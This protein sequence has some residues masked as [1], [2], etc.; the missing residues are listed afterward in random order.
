MKNGW[1]TARILK[2]TETCRFQGTVKP[3]DSCVI[4]IT[5]EDQ[6]NGDTVFVD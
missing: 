4:K 5:S 2:S 6:V 3:D 1:L